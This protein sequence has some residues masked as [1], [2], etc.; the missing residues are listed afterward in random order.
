[1]Y[2]TVYG[3]IHQMYLNTS[4]FKYILKYLNIVFKY[5]VSDVTKIH[6]KYKNIFKHVF[7]YICI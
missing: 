6:F 3:T 2:F 4:V 1:M 7:K 5:M